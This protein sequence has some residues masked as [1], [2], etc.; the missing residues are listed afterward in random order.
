MIPYG[1]QT[2]T[3]E[4]IQRVADVLNSDFLTQ[5]PWVPAFES[6]VAKKTG[7]RHTVATSSATA[8]LHL[9][10]RALDVGPG[11]R[12]WTSPITFVASANCALYCGA[13]ID[14]VDID[15]STYNLSVSALATRL[16]DAHKA[17]R[18]PKVVIPVHMCG[19]PCDMEAIRELGQEYG[20]AIIEDASHAIGSDYKGQPTGNCQYSDITVF[21][22][23]PVK[24]I[25][26]G[27]GGMALTNAPDL[28]RRME[29]LRS[30]GITREPEQMDDPPHGSWYYQQIDLGYNYRMTDL[31]AALGYSQL[32][33]LDSFIAR[34]RVL[35]ANYSNA[36]SDLPVSLPLEASA[37]NSSWHL[38]VIRVDATRSKADR[39][40]LFNKLREQNIGVHVHYI[41]VHTQPF[42]RAMGFD[43]GQFPAAEAY[44]QEALTLPIY[45]ALTENQQAHVVETLRA[46]LT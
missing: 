28:A 11:D 39:L 7:A 13:S 44:Y 9:A 1:K 19:Q 41:P 43:W 20:F 23:H 3:P 4:D 27:E 21:S 29:L 6:A 18:L 8:A 5:G 46:L 26:S 25:T 12:V 2:I 15:P 45:P 42:F 36:L 34:R 10:C 33:K 24:I 31:Q 17:N 30:H 40:T 37:A 32:E 38:Y 14:F 35:A 22:F 16:A